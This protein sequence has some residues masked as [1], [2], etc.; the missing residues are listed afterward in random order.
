[1][2]NVIELFHPVSGEPLICFT[3]Q[4]KPLIKYA[5]EELDKK[6]SSHA[7]VSGVQDG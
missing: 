2:R 5:L 4:E 6:T 1:M 7:I 3:E